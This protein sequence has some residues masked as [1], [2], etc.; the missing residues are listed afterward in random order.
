VERR[1]VSKVRDSLLN[2]GFEAHLKHMKTQPKQNL[3][4]LPWLYLNIAYLW[5]K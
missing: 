4:P 2:K 5:M 3:S 1:V